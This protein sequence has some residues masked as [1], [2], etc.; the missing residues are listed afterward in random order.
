ME[1]FDIKFDETFTGVVKQQ[2]TSIHDLTAEASKKKKGGVKMIQVENLSKVFT[3]VVKKK[4]LKGFL[5]G[6]KSEVQFI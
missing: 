4:G 5:K 6:E 2:L 3:K 1:F